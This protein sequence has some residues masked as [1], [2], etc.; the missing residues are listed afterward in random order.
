MK[1]MHDKWREQGKAE[2]N[3]RKLPIIHK[4][5]PANYIPILAK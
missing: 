3:E 4:S 5:R 1:E 2:E